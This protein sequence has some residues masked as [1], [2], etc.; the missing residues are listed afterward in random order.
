MY[1]PYPTSGQPQEPQRMQPPGSVLNAVRLMYVGAALSGLGIVISLLTIGSLKSA[2][3][4]NDPTFTSTQLHAAEAVAV[5]SVIVSGLIGIGLWL[6]MAWANRKGRNWARVV[7]SVLFAFNT[8][9]V[10]FS[11]ARPHASLGLIFTI[12]VWLVGAGAIMLIWSKQSAPFY[13]QPT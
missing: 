8:I 2:I 7:A 4:A 3:R 10:F 5:G 11:L 1:Q 9:G 6:W 12:L 13:R